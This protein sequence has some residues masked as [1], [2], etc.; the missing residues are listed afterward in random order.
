MSDD[1]TDM[2]EELK[3]EMALGTQT[4]FFRSA[5]YQ[6]VHDRSNLRCLEKLRPATKDDAF[7]TAVKNLSEKLDD[8]RLRFAVAY[9]SLGS[10]GE[11][12]K[13][14]LEDMSRL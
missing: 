6:A 11:K 9:Y 7:R 10:D 8:D 4:D 14:V 1:G 2:V 3:K 5:L 12:A 13:F